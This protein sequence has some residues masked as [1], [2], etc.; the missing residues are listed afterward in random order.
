MQNDTARRQ[1]IARTILSQLGR[2]FSI[3]T[4]AKN[5]VAMESGLSFRVPAQKG[6]GVNH[7]EITLTPADLYDVTFRSIRGTTVK[8]KSQVEGVYF[9]QLLDVFEN[10]TGLYAT[11]QPRG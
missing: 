6:K 9:D 2:G 7:V 4:G 3:I 10:A 5:F 8:V 1:E 11:L